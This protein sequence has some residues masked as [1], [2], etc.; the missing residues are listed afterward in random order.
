MDDDFPL[1]MVPAE[2]RRGGIAPFLT[3]R[4]LARL[5][6]AGRLYYTQ[7]RHEA[8]LWRTVVTQAAP[9]DNS[10]PNQYARQHPIPR[11]LLDAVSFQVFAH[12]NWTSEY[13]QI[14]TRVALPPAE[15]QTLLRMLTANPNYIVLDGVAPFTA[16]Q[17]AEMAAIMT[18]SLARHQTVV[19][20]RPR[21]QQAY[22]LGLNFGVDPATILPVVPILR[23]LVLNSVQMAGPTGPLVAALRDSLIL[24]DLRTSGEPASTQFAAEVMRGNPNVTTFGL[25][26]LGAPISPAFMQLM[27]E[28]W[29]FVVE[30][31]LDICAIADTAPAVEILR[32][33]HMLRNLSLT[34]NAITDADALLWAASAHPALMLL[35]LQGNRIARLDLAPLIAM[36]TSRMRRVNFTANPIAA[37]TGTATAEQ[38]RAAL[39]MRMGLNQPLDL[40]GL[41]AIGV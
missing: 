10:A 33:L 16:E 18:A 34:G 4:E 32:D 35:Q 19:R 6:K 31:H 41:E 37:V 14:K 21:N 26:P 3:P 23:M 24:R 39:A 27:R 38:L 9:A 11:T 7:F 1:D 20:G 22:T 25:V 15:Y 30:L 2:V 13:I 29:V 8:G 5:M 17:F 12:S 40:R 28:P 36:A